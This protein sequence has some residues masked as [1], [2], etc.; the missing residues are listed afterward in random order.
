[1]RARGKR[2]RERR[3]FGGKWL[4]AVV[5]TAS[6][7]AMVGTVQAGHKAGHKKGGGND[8]QVGGDVSG[9]IFTQVEFLETSL[10][11]GLPN[12]LVANDANG[13]GDYTNDPLIDGVDRVEAQIG[14]NRNLYIDFNPHKKKAAI[15]TVEFR[16]LFEGMLVPDGGICSDLRGTTCE[17]TAYDGTQ[18]VDVACEDSFPIIG[19]IG[20]QTATAADAIFRVLGEDF[21]DVPI[22]YTRYVNGV[23]FFKGANGVVW[24]LFFGSRPFPGGSDYGPCS[25]LMKITRISDGQWT[26]T[27]QA[28]HEGYLYLEGNK[29]SD[30]RTFVGVATLPFS[31][32]ITA[33]SEE[34]AP[35]LEGYVPPEGE[36]LDDALLYENCDPL[37]AP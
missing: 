4:M 12:A 29:P 22:G 15:R 28:P 14:R 35:P 24:G 3:K 23:L 19:G 37:P 25:E 5:F 10:C 30:R 2:A 36:S 6:A 16:N 7:L 27:T 21:D 17:P 11:D 8:G 13:D 26:V 18:F 34:V 31:L 33:L 32:E 20:D 1:M 9:W